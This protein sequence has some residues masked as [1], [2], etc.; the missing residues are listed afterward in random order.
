MKEFDY[1]NPIIKIGVKD[2][3]FLIGRVFEHCE[4]VGMT[5]R[6]LSAFKSSLRDIFWDWF[7]QY[8]D[9]PAGLA[10]PSKQARIVTGIEPKTT[11][12]LGEVKYAQI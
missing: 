8:I 6:Q 2:L 3:D 9:N 4:L 5:D 1:D 7:N 12:T 10:D 11:S